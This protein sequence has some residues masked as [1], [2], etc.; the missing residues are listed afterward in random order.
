[1]KNTI[2]G[3]SGS[4]SATLILATELPA[5]TIIAIAVVTFLMSAARAQ[6]P[7]Q[8]NSVSTTLEGAIHLSWDSNPGEIYEIDEADSLIDP[9]TGAITWNMLYQDYPSQGTNTFWLDTGNYFSDPTIVHPRLSSARFYRVVLTGTNT[10]PTTPF[11]VIESPTNETVLNGNVTVVVIAGTDQAF[12]ETLLYVDGQEMNDADTITN[13]TDDSGVTNFTQAT[14]TLN[15]CEWPNGPHS[16]FATIACQSGPTGPHDIPDVLIGYGVS[17]FVSVAFSNLITRI[18][19]SQPFFAPE[20]G[21]TQKVSAVFAANVNWTLQIQDVDTN[22]VRTASGSGG[23]MLFNWDGNGNGGTNLPVGNYTYLISA[24]TNGQALPDF[25]LALSSPP[26]NAA[27]STTPTGSEGTRLWAMPKDGTGSIVPLALYPPHYNTNGLIIFEEPTSWRPWATKS[28]T[29][30]DQPGPLDT[31]GGG[32]DPQG[33]S[34]ASS[35]SSRA[36]RRPPVAPVRGRAGVYGLAY[37]TYSANGNGYTIAPPDNG[38]HIGVKVGLEGRSPGTS[39]F[40]YPPLRRYKREAN[41]FIGQM[42][43]ANWS[44]GFA[45][46]DNTLGINDLRAS[47]SNIFNQVKLGLLLLHGTY[48][49]TPDYNAFGAEQVYFPI[50]SG[51]SAQYLGITEMSLGNADTNGLKWMGILACSSMNQSDWSSMV[52]AGLLPYN[53]NLHLFL[54]ASSVIWTGDHVASYWAKYVTVG[55]TN[56]P[57]MTVESAWYASA[58]DAYAETR[59]AYTNTMRFSAAGDPA[60]RTDTLQNYSTP[61]GNYFYN[62]TQV[63]P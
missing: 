44:Q 60:C 56:T 12:P 29:A 39:T 26:A 5:K 40:V 61:S 9:N 37:Q 22:T 52:A 3:T 46:V 62:S 34:G 18:S 47:G 59:Y 30:S 36:P 58:R 38:L 31:G 54:G 55:K 20:D 23:S 57:P 48:G 6:N 10:T 13:W 8:F 42:K 21:T 45:R 50:T 24:Q 51:H 53:N 14:Y 27:A 25:D 19:F 7:L 15:T 28:S 32:D 35:R 17:P 43:T 49:T 1:M 2:T 63:W 16:L 11:V 41:N 33:Y 4:V